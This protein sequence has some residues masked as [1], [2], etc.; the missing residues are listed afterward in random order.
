MI[1]VANHKEKVYFA[2][3]IDLEY[4]YELEEGKHDEGAIKG[5]KNVRKV[6]QDAFDQIKD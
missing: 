6:V 1:L 4:A 5:L 2:K 3:L